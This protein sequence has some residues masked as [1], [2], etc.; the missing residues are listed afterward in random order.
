MKKIFALAIF[1]SLL[2]VSVGYSQQESYW[3]IQY[4]TGFSTG[5]MGTYISSP[6]FRGAIIEYRNAVQPNLLVGVDVG[7][8]VFYERK[9]EATYTRG[10]EALSGIQYRTQNE[11]P[12]LISADY[13]ISIDTRLKPYAGLGIGTLYSQRS[14]DMGQWRL[15]EDP[16]HFAIKPEVGFL[17]EMSYSTSF[18]FAAKYY[19]GFTSGDLPAQGYFSISAGLAFNL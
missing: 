15:K 2:F 18:K 17:Y 3:S 1:F 8:N 12:I 19:N 14:T 4:A 13:F 6:S 7:W 16:W 5:D 11:L 9:D 10:T